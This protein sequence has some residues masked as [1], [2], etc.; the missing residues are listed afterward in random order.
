MQ[1]PT[2]YVAGGRRVVTAAS[3]VRHGTLFLSLVGSFL[4]NAA[5]GGATWLEDAVRGG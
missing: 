4:T 3:A 2:L 5:L 1:A